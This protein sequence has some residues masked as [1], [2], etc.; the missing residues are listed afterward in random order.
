MPLELTGGIVTDIA[1]S[2][3]PEFLNPDGRVSIGT[4][5]NREE[6]TVLNVY[7]P[8]TVADRFIGVIRFIRGTTSIGHTIGAPV[9]LKP[10]SFDIPLPGDGFVSNKKEIAYFNPKETVG[11]G[12]I[13]GL[14]TTRS[15][16]MEWIYNRERYI[17]PVYPYSRS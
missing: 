17:N 15:Y 11:L 5:G 3:I 14:T 1:V 16:T 7:K 9:D 12:T 4:V 10:N 6:L 8:N 2:P 13:A